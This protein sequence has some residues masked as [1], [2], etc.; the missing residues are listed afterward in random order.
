MV[1]SLAW[2]RE[3]PAV[4]TA[5]RVRRDEALAVADLVMACNQADFGEPLHTP[6]EQEAAWSRPNFDLAGDAWVVVAPQGQ[7]AAY[8]DVWARA[9][10]HV[11]LEGCVHP[12]H[13]GRGLGT[14]LARQ[15]DARAHERLRAASQASPAEREAETASPRPG[16]A[17]P[18]PLDRPARLVT[19]MLAG[20]HAA[21]RIFEQAGYQ[22]DGF[23]WEMRIDL[24]GLP[25][26]PE[27][28]AGVSVRAFVP[29]LDDQATHAVDSAA[30]SDLP[31]FVPASLAEWQQRLMIPG[32]FDPSL[33]F[34]AMAGEAVIGSALGYNFPDSGWVARLSV[35]RAWRRQGVAL[36]LL[37]HAMGEL[38]R[39]GQR[40]MELGVDAANATGATRVYERA[41]MHIAREFVRYVKIVKEN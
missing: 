10:Y 39:R 26:P 19:S 30:F 28:P 18:A 24:D 7:L 25:P 22:L 3:L 1:T 37:R 38:Y 4:Y 33:W 13:R 31:D 29:G 32:L 41:G 2:T 21:R 16:A 23:S 5:R 17:R 20:D 27:W 6:E 35:D 11:H 12:D 34:V 14:W 40:R 8:G 36:G 9:S 15:M